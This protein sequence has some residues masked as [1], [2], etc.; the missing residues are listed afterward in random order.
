MNKKRLL[1]LADFLET[2]PRKRF[3]MQ[4]W[5]GDEW[6]GKEDLSCG[7]SACAMGWATT[8]PSFRKLGLRLQRSYVWGHSPAYGSRYG[9]D[10]A[11]KFFEID[12]QTA[13]LLFAPAKEYKDGSISKITPKQVAKRIRKVVES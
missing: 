3:D 8:I 6:K 13:T 4:T 12:L 5:V 11:Q 7:T 10:A 2:V 9:L 1:K